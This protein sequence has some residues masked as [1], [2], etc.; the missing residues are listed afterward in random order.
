MLQSRHRRPGKPE[1]HLQQPGEGTPQVEKA[2]L[3][4]TTKIRYSPDMSN[5]HIPYSI[6]GIATCSRAA[7]CWTT[8]W[9]TRPT[10]SSPSTG[11]P[12]SAPHSATSTPASLLSQTHVCGN[13]DKYQKKSSRSVPDVLHVPRLLPA[14]LLQAARGLLRPPRDPLAL[15]PL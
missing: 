10:G 12:S 8:R 13:N 3:P 2:N 11:S 1:F 14:V 6:A 5:F 9:C 4:I 7:T 15:R